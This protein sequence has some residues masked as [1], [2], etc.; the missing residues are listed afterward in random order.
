MQA[1][2]YK[3]LHMEWTDPTR[4]LDPFTRACMQE[5]NQAPTEGWEEMAEEGGGR[6]WGWLQERRKVIQGIFFREAL[7]QLPTGRTSCMV[8]IASDSYDSFV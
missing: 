6:K 8:G 7:T 4:V 1:T 5:V 2:S 3:I